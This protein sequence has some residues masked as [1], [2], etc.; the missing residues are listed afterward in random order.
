[1]F[2]VVYYGYVYNIELKLSFTEV[3]ESY[4]KFQVLN[5]NIIVN[6]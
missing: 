6:V 1:M 4:G 2:M 3:F 5:L